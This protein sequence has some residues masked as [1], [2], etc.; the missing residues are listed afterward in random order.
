MSAGELIRGLRTGRGFTLEQVGAAVGR[1]KG[2]ISKIELGET[3]PPSDLLSRLLD[4]LGATPGEAH[5]VLRAMSPP[6]PV[7]TTAPNATDGA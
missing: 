4:V 3:M 5:Q 2:T 1:S 6:D 7:A